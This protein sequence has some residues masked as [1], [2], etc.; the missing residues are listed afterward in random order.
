MGGGGAGAG[1]K[2]ALL[3]GWAMDKGKLRSIVHGTQNRRAH[4]MPVT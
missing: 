2:R 4:E 1:E 3:A